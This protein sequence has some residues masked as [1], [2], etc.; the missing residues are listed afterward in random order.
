MIAALAGCTALFGFDKDVFEQGRAASDVDSSAATSDGSSLDDGSTPSDRDRGVLDP[1]FGDGGSAIVTTQM[2]AIT[3]YPGALVGE[4]SAHLDASE[5]ILIACSAD[6]TQPDPGETLLSTYAYRVSSHGTLDPTFGTTDGGGL[7]IPIYVPAI[8]NRPDGGVLLAGYER[9][10]VYAHYGMGKNLLLAL[11]EGGQ[12]DPSFADAGRLTAPLTTDTETDKLVAALAVG[13]KVLL[14]AEFVKANDDFNLEGTA[15][16]E[17]D[18]KTAS[19]TRVVNPR[20]AAFPNEIPTSAARPTDRRTI[21]FA[22]TRGATGYNASDVAVS[23]YD[24][25]QVDTTFGTG[26]RAVKKVFSGDYGATVLG[27]VAPSA[28]RY[29]VTA[30][31]PRAPGVLVQFLANGQPDTSFGDGGVKPLPS[32]PIASAPGLD[33]RAALLSPDGKIVAA[34]SFVFGNGSRQPFLVRLTADGELDPVFGAAGWFLPS[35]GDA[36]IDGTFDRLLFTKSGQLLAIGTGATASG[37]RAFHLFR[38]Q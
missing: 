28:D 25:D 12:I 31:T 38:F 37:A 4:C 32:A 35:F 17:L 26:G 1:T 29:L 5:R 27:M 14:T 8:V 36:A 30:T 24:G 20:P 21:L 16:L 2:T 15:W 7:R 9:G 11:T 22:A 6:T 18:P 34:G 23:A 3:A 10:P 33:V 19:F 13:D